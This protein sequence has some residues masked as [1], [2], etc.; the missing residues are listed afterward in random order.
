MLDIVQFQDL[1]IDPTLEELGMYS[2]AASELLLGTA[3]HESMRF[4]F[5]TQ[6]DGDDDPYDDAMGFFQTERKT[7]IDIW[8]NYLIYRDGL[9]RT[10]LSVCSLP[11]EPVPHAVIWNLRYATC[12][13][14]LCYRRAKEPLPP[15]GNVEA[16]ATYW[17]KHY[18]TGGGKGSV[19]DY[20]T[21][22][23]KGHA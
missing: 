17:K 6:V 23:S 1:I 8:D 7:I 14:R 16:Q 3:L 19:Q 13:A 15:A 2:T 11:G 22:W 21:N 20:I 5:L 4:T 18:N 10:V 9:T 12:M